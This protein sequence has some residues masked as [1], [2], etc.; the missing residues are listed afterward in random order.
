MENF[1]T[2]V[3]NTFV[4]FNQV[5]NCFFTLKKSELLFEKCSYFESQSPYDFKISNDSIKIYP[6]FNSTWNSLGAYQKELIVTVGVAGQGKKNGGASGNANQSSI[7]TLGSFIIPPHDI[8]NLINE[9]GD[10]KSRNI[11][12]IPA[13]PTNT[14][15]T[16]PE[17]KNTK[18]SCGGDGKLMVDP[19]KP[20]EVLLGC[21]E[22][23]YSRVENPFPITEAQAI[24]N[25]NN[26]LMQNTGTRSENLCGGLDSCPEGCT[27]GCS[28]AY[29]LIP[30]S[31]IAKKENPNSTCYFCNVNKDQSIQYGCTNCEFVSSSL[32]SIS[33]SSKS[34][35]SS[36]DSS[37]SRLS[38]TP[39]ST[40]D[41]SSSNSS[42]SDSSA[43]PSSVS[44]NGSNKSKSSS[45]RT[46]STTTSSG[47]TMSATPPKA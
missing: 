47:N 6:V 44:S 8:T 28:L 1:S 21:E 45:S 14:T 7:K 10:I 32:K 25:C 13:V 36:V 23:G 16:S 9:S 19:K 41:K 24:A 18:A 15:S 30:D 42:K 5:E 43:N 38:S 46:S 12:I 17:N 2:A 20:G 22:Y 27:S 40:S 26:L 34:S 3:S 35:S 11:K 31:A 39:S 29:Q 37:S 33:S 4:A